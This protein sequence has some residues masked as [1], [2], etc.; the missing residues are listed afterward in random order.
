[1]GYVYPLI[2]DRYRYERLT[3]YEIQVRL[4]RR[5]ASLLVYGKKIPQRTVRYL[6][7]PVL[8][9]C[10]QIRQLMDVTLIEIEKRIVFLY[11]QRELFILIAVY[12]DIF[13]K[14]SSA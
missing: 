6:I 4:K 2:T 9:Y 1:M 5:L 11:I 13:I 10:R 14:S 7:Y 12:R 3:L 8:R